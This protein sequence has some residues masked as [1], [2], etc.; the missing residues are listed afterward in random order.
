MR[1][2]RGETD[3]FSV[4][5]LDV[6]ACGFGA[7]I[8]LLM[9]TKS[10]E[11]ISIEF[12]DVPP[13]GAIT[14]LQEQLFAIRG[15]TTILN[16]DLN[17]KQEQLS[18]MKDRI[19]RLQRDLSDVQG[20]HQ[21]SNQL[22]SEITDEMGRLAIAQQSMTEE[23]QRLLA[24][25]SAPENNAIGGVP[26]DSEYIIFVI[27]T[28]GSM[29]G[30]AWNKMLGVIEDTLNVYPEVKGIQIMNDMGDYM[31][32]SYRG[33]W[34]PDTPGTRNNIISTL[35]TWNPFSNS[36]PVEGVTRAINTFYSPDKKISIY[37]I[38]DDFQPGGSIQEVL[39]TIDRINVEDENGDRLVRIHG[40]GFPV[41]FAGQA[42]FQQSVYRYST[43]MR[44]MTQR[45]G[46]TFVGLN[47][48]Q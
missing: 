39:Q 36:S 26:V 22:S 1:R 35:R 2:K 19:A 9:I 20:R 4:S 46:G 40:I 7:M 27:D 41:I 8:I 44:E 13:E 11:P 38:G 14:E 34:I 17:A 28:S 10:G 30:N 3:S 48:F 25:S 37:V 6:A 24:N 29:F 12:V 33:Q 45:N 32:A 5:F 21:T 15:E 43:L 18:A 47:D 42:R 16:R 23:M 31:F